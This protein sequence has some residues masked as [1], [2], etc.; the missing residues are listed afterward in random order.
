MKAPLLLSLCLSCLAWA[1]PLSAHPPPPPAEGR[2]SACPLATAR[3]LVRSERTGREYQL[4]IAVPEQPAPAA[5]HPVIYVLDP[6]AMF[7]T[8]VETVRAYERRRHGHGPH[9]RAVV[10][11]IGYPPGADG[12]AERTLD[13]TP[14]AVDDPRVRKPNGGAAAFLDFIEDELKPIVQRDY[15]ID[16]QRQALFGHSF[17]GLFVLYALTARPGSFQTYVSASPSLWY[18]DGQLAGEIERMSA[19]RAGE[20]TP[21]RVLVVAGEYE[22]T[23]S[24]AVL[25][26]ADADR[27]A[28]DLR[29]RAQ[30]DR[31][32]SAAGR[33][34]SMPGT[35]AVFQEIAGEDHGTVIPA[36][37]SRGMAFILA[38]P[39][40]PPVPDAQAYIGMTAEERYRLRLRVREL[41]DAQRIPWLNRLKATLHGGLSAEQQEALHDERN[42][43]D[44]RHGTRPHAVN[45]D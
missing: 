1:S 9:T 39:V 33:L 42:A 13:L 45:A 2:P 20:R 29:E 4:S 24:P 17:G 30:V 34:A 31:A 22:Q 19:R 32:R 26:E 16:P 14:V 40:P 21:V 38:G 44:R 8:V 6:D 15:P 35:E 27:I 23:P 10:V 5:G 3:S 7:H 41:P 12:R 11:G 18:A 28:A 36:A 37:I 43:M 25:Q